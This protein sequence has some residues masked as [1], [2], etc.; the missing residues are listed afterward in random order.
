MGYVAVYLPRVWMFLLSLIGDALL[1]RVFAVY[2]TDN[3]LSAVIT[4]ASTWT[5]LIAV[6]RNTNFA[7]ESI[8]LTAILAGCF[9]WAPGTP[10]PLFYLSAISL[11]LGTFC[12]PV[13]FVFLLVPLIYLSSLWGKAGVKPVPY[14]LAA[15][16]GIAIFA[17]WC[18]IWVAIDSMFY[19][20]FKILIDGVPME[21]VEMFLD[22]VFTGS[23]FAY[24]GSLVYTPIAMAKTVLN[25]KYLRTIAHNTTPGQMFLSL[26]GILGPLF[27]VLM[28][29]SYKGMQVAV[30]ELMAEVKAAT[31]SKKGKKKKGKKG[32]AT[33]E[34]EEELL[35]FFD[36]IQTTLLL[37]LLMEVVQNNDRLGI[38]S[39][40]SLIPPAVMCMPGSIFGAKSSPRFRLVHIIFTVGMVVFYGLLHQSGV[41]RTMLSLG[42]G[43]GRSYLSKMRTLLST[44]E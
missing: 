9:G 2:E 18:A 7:L 3:A 35:V 21:S 33:K 10:R 34:R 32:S 6:T 19:G 1:L 36:T 37:G 25:K 8:C 11:A 44:R 41:Q 40:L 24:K 42:A 26:P 5:S 38:I 16:E 28:R 15:M 13:F 14:I 27:I 17:F 20:K 31:N 4:F 43:G 12:R 23:K 22:N 30:K 29:E 39:L